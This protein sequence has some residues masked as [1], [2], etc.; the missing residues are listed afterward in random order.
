[1]KCTA[2]G[3]ALRAAGTTHHYVE[4]GLENVFLRGVEVRKCESCGH[5]EVA[6]PNI[7]G[8]HTS[9]ARA[10]VARPSAM[11]RDEFRFLRTYLGH[12]SQDFAKLLGVT[13]ETMSRWQSGKHAIPRTADL[14]VRFLVTRT[15][16]RID[17]TDEL[18]AK[19]RPRPAKPQKLALRLKGNAWEPVRAA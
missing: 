11:T 18:L 15:K 13:P 6:I 10:I 2:C 9:L 8:L 17:Y 5:V 7:G 12:S 16:P 19:I 3:G 1:M 14:L 4:S